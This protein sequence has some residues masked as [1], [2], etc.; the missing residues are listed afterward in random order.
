MD[1]KLLFHT[2]EL[3]KAKFSYLRLLSDALSV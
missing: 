2:D 3:F 1:I